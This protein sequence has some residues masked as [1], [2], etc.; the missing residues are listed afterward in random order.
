MYLPLNLFHSLKHHF[1]MMALMTS[2]LPRVMTEERSMQ[3]EWS[4]STESHTVPEHPPKTG[5]S[6]S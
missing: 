1:E 2:S 6:I 3:L 5:Q 4:Q